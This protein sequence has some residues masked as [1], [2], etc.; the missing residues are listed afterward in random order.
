MRIIIFHLKR[1]LPDLVENIS[2]IEKE[3]NR[4]IPVIAGGG[5]YSGEDMMRILDL[6]ASAD[7]IRDK[8]CNNDRV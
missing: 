6:G 7:S 1:F 2:R 5:I 3:N 4:K 8:I